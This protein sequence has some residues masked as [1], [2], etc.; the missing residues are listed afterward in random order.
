[1]NMRMEVVFIACI[2]FL[3]GAFPLFA[4]DTTVTGE[5]TILPFN[6]T[7]ERSITK[8]LSTPRE[9]I[10]HAQKVTREVATLAAFA[11]IDYSQSMAMFSDSRYYELNPLLGKRP[12]SGEM[13]RFGLIGIGLF[14]ILAYYLPEPWRQIAVDSII[15]SEQFNIE[16]NRRIYQGWSQSGPPQRNRIIGGVPI[17]ICF[18]F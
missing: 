1:M 6:V 4:A 5:V 10:S 17:V 7:I 14:T 11:A 16:D 8:D 9:K 18:R 15:A 13:L 12:N 3:W 2:L